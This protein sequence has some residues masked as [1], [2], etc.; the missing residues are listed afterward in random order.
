MA[1]RRFRLIALDIDGTILD[2][3]GNLRPRMKR[4]IAAAQ[5]AGAAVTLATGRR[6]R[7]TV[8]VADE[9]DIRVPLVLNNGALVCDRH[10]QRFVFH[11]PLAGRTARQAVRIAREH[12]TAPVVYRHA[13]SGPDVFYEKLTA[14]PWFVAMLNRPDVVRKVDDLLDVIDPGP[15]KM[16]VFERVAVIDRIEAD[17]TGQLTGC[18]RIYK[19]PGMDGQA[20]LE[21]LHGTCSKWDGVRRVA[22]LLGVRP[23]EVLAIGDGENDVEMLARAGLGVAMGNSPD[24]VKAAAAE[25]AASNDDDGAAEVIERYVIAP[26]ARSR[27][28]GAI[29]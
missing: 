15:E 29:V 1:N 5:E 7:A 23:S 27:R 14:D 9:L 26:A 13:A 16:V 4:A 19:S 21:L 11:R 3:K 6:H 10:A 22:R 20:A 8:A 28:A 18:Y 12:G 2:S 25:V 17:W 24:A